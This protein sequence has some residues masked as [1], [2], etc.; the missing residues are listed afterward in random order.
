MT[1]S[2]APK[3]C[4]FITWKLDNF[5]GDSYNISFTN[6]SKVDAYRV[7]FQIIDGDNIIQDTSTAFVN[8]SSSILRGTIHCSDK[9]WIKLI[10][11][12]KS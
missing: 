11:C 9:A 10:N 8:A 7:W 3:E 4:E 5:W 6:S 12:V 1:N 2:E